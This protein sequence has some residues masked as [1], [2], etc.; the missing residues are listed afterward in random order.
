M[1]KLL[2]FIFVISFTVSSCSKQE[3]EVSNGLNYDKLIIGKWALWESVELTFNSD[4]TMQY[5]SKSSSG[6][7]YFDGS[8]NIYGRHIDIV[9]DNFVNGAS[10]YSGTIRE[11]TN[12]KFDIDIVNTSSGVSNHWEG[13]RIN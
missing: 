6:A 1:R 5:V 12:E 2:L 3:M 10:G 13:Y 8:W 7:T 9:F 4:N 11:L